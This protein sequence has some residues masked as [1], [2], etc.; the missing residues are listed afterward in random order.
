MS[1]TLKYI[2]HHPLA[3]KNRLGAIRRYFSWQIGSRI[4]RYPIIM[5]FVEKSVLVIDNG[6]KGATGNIYCGLHEFADMAFLLHFL[7]ESDDFFDLGANIGSY[8]VLASSVV[9]A[10]TISVEPLPGTHSLLLRNIW[11][12]E[13]GSKVLTIQAACSSEPGELLMTADLDCMNHVVSGDYVGSTTKVP[14]ST[15]DSLLSNRTPSCWKVDIEGHE[16]NA[17]K[18]AVSAITSAKL[19]AVIMEGDNPKIQQWMTDAGFRLMCYDPFKRLL[20]SDPTSHDSKNHLWIRDAA[21][22]QNRCKTA[23]KISVVGQ[24]V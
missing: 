20:T 1:R 13:V 3:R 6:M 22:V 2:W 9:G 5:P 10:S 16:L 11:A 8:T 23:R 7:R 12:N 24:E 17:L 18:G 21:F 15:I 14:V 4:L 19:Q